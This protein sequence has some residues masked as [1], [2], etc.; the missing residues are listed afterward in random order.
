M[1]NLKLMKEIENNSYDLRS[2]I[3]ENTKCDDLVVRFD[4]TGNETEI[5]LVYE[6]NNGCCVDFKVLITADNIEAGTTLRSDSFEII[7]GDNEDRRLEIETINELKDVIFRVKYYVEFFEN[8]L[9]VDDD[10]GKIIYRQK[11]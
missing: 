3:T 10:S 9:S 2:W 6:L 1:K 4:F 11:I 7:V 5:T 8:R